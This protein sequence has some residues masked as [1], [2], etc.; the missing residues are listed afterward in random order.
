MWQHWS[1]ETLLLAAGCASL[2]QTTCI[3]L[4]C[5]APLQAVQDWSSN[6]LPFSCQQS[7]KQQ[8]LSVLKNPSRGQGLL[9]YLQCASRWHLISWALHHAVH[10][11]TQA[12]EPEAWCVELEGFLAAVVDA[13]LPHND[14]VGGYIQGPVGGAEADVVQACTAEATPVDRKQLAA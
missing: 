10:V 1:A 7:S 8:G 9:P 11:P 13:D 3:A 14:T 6:S 12:H 4:Q 5:M 2:L